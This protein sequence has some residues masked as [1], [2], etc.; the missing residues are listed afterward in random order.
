MSGMYLP[1]WLRAALWLLSVP[2]RIKWYFTK[3]K[4]W[5]PEYEG[6]VDW[7]PE[8]RRAPAD[9]GGEG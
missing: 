3:P 8:E 5:R 2:H 9:E 7:P 6:L 4:D 1:K